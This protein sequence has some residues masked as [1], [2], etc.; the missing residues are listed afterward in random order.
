MPGDKKPAF[1]ESAAGKGSKGS[2]KYRKQMDKHRAT[3]QRFADARAKSKAI[4]KERYESY[5]RFVW[6]AVVSLV[7]RHPYHPEDEREIEGERCG[8]TE[9]SDWHSL[10][11]KAKKDV[12]TKRS[13]DGLKTY[14]FAKGDRKR[15][16][17][18]GYDDAI[19]KW[20]KSH[21]EVDGEWVR[22][23]PKLF[24]QK[25]K[26]DADGKPVTMTN[27]KGDTVMQ[28][29]MIPRQVHIQD[30]APIGDLLNQ[31]L[32]EPMF[33]SRYAFALFGG[34]WGEP[35][36]G[37]TENP[38]IP[39][40]IAKV[41]INKRTGEP[42][43]SKQEEK[44]V[45]MFESLEKSS[46]PGVRVEN[47]QVINKRGVPSSTFVLVHL[48]ECPI[49]DQIA[50][51]LVHILGKAANLEGEPMYHISHWE[52][53]EQP[54]SPAAQA[55]KSKAAAGSSGFQGLPI[56][57]DESEEE[58]FEDDEDGAAP[59]PDADDDCAAVVTGDA[60]DF[61]D[62]GTADAEPESDDAGADQEDEVEDQ[63][64]ATADAGAK[65]SV[66][67]YASR[68]SAPKPKIDLSTDP[69]VPAEKQG[70]KVR[71]KKGRGRVQMS[72]ATFMASD[73]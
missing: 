5:L 15:M 18:N 63:G 25:L 34:N 50:G 32:D 55:D 4:E 58:V 47:H 62:D 67:S 20:E 16:M 30:W 9:M 72:L 68:V 13:R 33:G 10:I 60:A 24:I 28:G 57:G 56:E 42:Y 70:G 53:K 29:E 49:G 12:D 65:P 44:L 22:K 27:A 2:S 41:K 45:R 14:E 59:A 23:T 39:V 21:E 7:S 8:L 35:Y 1:T 71:A 69:D 54:A 6:A 37:P 51:F 73:Q 17:D 36:S 11:D 46:L 19:A 61:D 38:E 26:L 3:E 64:D 43:L 66:L 31:G 52:T 40:R 48:A